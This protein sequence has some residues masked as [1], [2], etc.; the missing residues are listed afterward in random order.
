MKLDLG[1]HV[2]FAVV[3]AEIT[4]LLLMVIRVQVPRLVM[5]RVLRPCELRMQSLMQFDKCQ[6][7]PG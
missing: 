1:A 2:G 7:V 6:V 4:E 5:L 3:E